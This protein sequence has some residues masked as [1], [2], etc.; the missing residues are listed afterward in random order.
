MDFL[1][2]FT[3]T[4]NIKDLYEALQL[5]RFQ[6][7]KRI[8]Y[9]NSTLITA[10]K[11]DVS[12]LTPKLRK[13]ILTA[14]PQ[15]NS[16]WLEVGEGEILAEDDTRPMFM[17]ANA[18]AAIPVLGSIPA[19]FPDI[20]SEQVIEYISLPDAPKE[21]FALKVSGSSMN[22]TANDGDYVIFIQPDN[23][24]NGDMVIVNNEWGESFLK[25]YRV[26]NG[27]ELL[28]SDNPEYPTVKPNEHYKIMGKVVD[29]WARK[30][31]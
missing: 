28:S 16:Q 19:G 11:R 18:S 6:F 17:K 27:E 24:K 22:P 8:G 2:Y 25:R 13:A 20:V 4:K 23:V 7:S 31:P 15:V 12:F 30:R 9:D 1:N 5:N 29:I 14:F 10:E 26:K 3:M 21:S